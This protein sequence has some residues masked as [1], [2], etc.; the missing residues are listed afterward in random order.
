MRRKR[1][2]VANPRAERYRCAILMTESSSRA[3]WMRLGSFVVEFN[4][5]KRERVPLECT[6][7]GQGHISR[8]WS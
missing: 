1:R 6:R 3:L 4:Y 5:G 7:A 2:M 8:C